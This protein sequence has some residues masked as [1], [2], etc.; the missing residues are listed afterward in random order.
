MSDLISKR[1]VLQILKSH[2]VLCDSAKELIENMN[3][4]D[5][6]GKECTEASGSVLFQ[7][8]RLDNG[9]WIYGS[10]VPLENGER[11]LFR[12]R[13]SFYAVWSGTLLYLHLSRC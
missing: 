2:G 10:L 13:K 9:E 5:L 7:G 4:V 12:K 1:E 6:T 8:Q 11:Q 3:T